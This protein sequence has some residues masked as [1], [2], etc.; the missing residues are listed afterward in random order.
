MQRS[1]ESCLWSFCEPWSFRL[2]GMI[3]HALISLSL[4]LLSVKK[5]FILELLLSSDYPKSCLLNCFPLFFFR[6]AVRFPCSLCFCKG[7]M[8]FVC[9]YKKSSN[10]CQRYVWIARCNHK[11]CSSAKCQSGCTFS[12]VGWYPDSQQ[13]NAC[14]THAIF[15]FASISATL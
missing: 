12:D 5:H 2:F 8:G 13:P 11:T 15:I 7:R 1:W 10:Q 9:L 6:G 3:S 14:T 4:I